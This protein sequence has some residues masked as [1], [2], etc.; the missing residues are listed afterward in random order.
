MYNN[1]LTPLI[2]YQDDDII[3]LNK[4]AGML[5]LDDD[6]GR[7]SL[8]AMVKDYL[9][10]DAAVDEYVYCAAMHRIDRPVSGVMLFAKNPAAARP[11]SIDMKQRKIRKFYCA[12][13][14]PAPG[15]ACPDEWSLLRQYIVR[16]RARAYMAAGDEPRAKAVALRYRV[17]VSDGE[18]GLVL[19][20][21]ITGKRHQ[22]RFQLSSIGMPITG[23]RFYGS[24]ETLQDGIIC[25][26][27]HYL[28]F[29]HPVTG[30][31]MTVTAPLP[32]H[33]A[34]V[35]G[36]PPGISDYLGY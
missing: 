31:P 29:T 18:C 30:K 27:A 26:H 23:D 11:L 25:L 19:V 10:G 34:G 4:P 35:T 15:T 36:T 9:R 28:M 3:V 16:R 12:L 14:N 32:P 6:S 8:Y 5:S 2:L 7:T 33:I 22:I 21:L 20:E 17:M 1:S 13:V 24:G